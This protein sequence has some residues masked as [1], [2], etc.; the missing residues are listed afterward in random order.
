MTLAG[1]WLGGSSLSILPDLVAMCGGYPIIND[2]GPSP[3][4]QSVHPSHL[5]VQLPKD[6]CGCQV[7]SFGAQM[8][9]ATAFLHELT[10][11]HTDLK[12]ENILLTSS[13]YNRTPPAYGSRCLLLYLLSSDRRFAACACRLW[14]WPDMPPRSCM[15]L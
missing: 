3:I 15:D 12:P 1:G 4:K 11:I 14:A 10:L 13:D 5:P 8:L 7:R 6:W 9:E 2:P